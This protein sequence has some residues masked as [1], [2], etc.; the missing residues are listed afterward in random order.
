[1]NAPLTGPLRLGMIP[2]IAPYMLPDILPG[3][4]ETFPDLQME[5]QEDVTHVLI[6][7]LRRG[8][9]DM[10][11]MAFPYDTKD[12]STQSLFDEN[13]YLAAPKGKWDENRRDGRMT[14]DIQELKDHSILLLDDEHCLRGHALAACQLQ[15]P[16]DRRSFRATSL[17]TLI[18]LVQQGFGITLLPEMVAMQRG[19]QDHLDL[20]PLGESAGSRK[21]GVAWRQNHPR[22]QEFRMLTATITY[23][24]KN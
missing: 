8:Q 19:L 21:I 11:I 4:Q 3:I 2:T 15:P 7:R 22:E 17:A 20:F 14:V 13:F 6:E 10:I 18:Q 9:I 1:M 23:I 16:T 12:L 5:I 24:L